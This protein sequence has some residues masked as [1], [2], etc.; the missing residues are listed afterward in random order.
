MEE[1]FALLL[2]LF[3]G[4]LIHSPLNEGSVY[5]I[6]TERKTSR[7]PVEHNLDTFEYCCLRAF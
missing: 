2:P 5:I 7:P 3:N 4:G 1:Q 6:T